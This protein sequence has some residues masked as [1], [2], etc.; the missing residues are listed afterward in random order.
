VAT[1]IAAL[2]EALR[3]CFVMAGEIPNAERRSGLEDELRDVLP[4]ERLILLGHQP[5]EQANQVLALADLVLL[6]SE[7]E[8]A[9][10]Q[11]PAKLSDALAMG[12]P[13]L[14]S[15][16]TPMR[17]MLARGWVVRATPGSLVEQ[18]KE[19]LGNRDL[20]AQQGKAAREGFLEE[21][22]LPVVA[23]RLAVCGE[24][25]IAAQMPLDLDLCNLL[26]D[27]GFHL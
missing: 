10:F 14:V 25:A 26:R 7:G 22:A 17:G 2:P 4:P 11:S 1:A 16:A 3:A 15:D 24:E 13:V 6:L 20:R 5:F 21:L 19:W 23:A 9:E 12:L 27:L 18:L 8:V